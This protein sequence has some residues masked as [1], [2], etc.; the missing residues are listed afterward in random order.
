[1]YVYSLIQT[2]KSNAYINFKKIPLVQICSSEIAQSNIVYFVFNMLKWWR[3]DNIKFWPLY[4]YTKI[5][6]AK[7][8]VILGMIL[9]R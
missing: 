5:I 4:P 1:M 7:L 2:L 3:H 8:F 6:F 9:V